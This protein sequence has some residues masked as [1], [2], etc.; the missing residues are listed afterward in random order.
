MTNERP[1]EIDHKVHIYQNMDFLFVGS[2][3]SFVVDYTDTLASNFAGIPVVD[4]VGIPVVYS[5]GD[6]DYA[7]DI[8]PVAGT[9]FPSAYSDNL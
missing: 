9:E 3:V 7:V 8:E 6:T 4:L 1:K 2:S 5:V